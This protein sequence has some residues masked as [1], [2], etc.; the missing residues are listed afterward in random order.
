M[1]IFQKIDQR[2]CQYNKNVL[3]ADFLNTN[4]YAWNASLSPGTF[5][6]ISA[7]LQTEIKYLN[8]GLRVITDNFNDNDIEFAPAN[9]TH[10]SFSPEVSGEHIFSFVVYSNATTQPVEVN[11]F[12]NLYEY[13]S[14]FSPFDPFTFAIGNNTEPEFSFQYRK[15]ETFFM[16]VILDS[17]KT[18]IMNWAILQDIASPFPGFDLTFD[19][20]KLE[21]IADKRQET[22]SFYTKPGE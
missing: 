2:Y 12:L 8:K 6:T 1:P 3:T 13:P 15:F 20:F 17:S 18:Y 16:R 14:L 21:Y 9:L 7:E 11:G 19:L 4:S 5:G 10:Y 22:P